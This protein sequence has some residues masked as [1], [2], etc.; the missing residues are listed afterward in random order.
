[1]YAPSEI[2]T[3]SE[4][5]LKDYPRTSS[6]KVRKVDLKRLLEDRHSAMDE[7]PTKHTGT[8]DALAIVKTAWARTLGIDASSIPLNRSIEDFADS[9]TAIRLKGHISRATGVE[10]DTADLM[11]AETIEGQAKLLASKIQSTN[12]PTLDI[13]SPSRPGPPQLDDILPAMGDADLFRQIRQQ[14]LQ[15]IKPL[16]FTWHD[17]VEDVLASWDL[18]HVIFGSVEGSG[19]V[20][21]RATVAMK[22]ASVQQLSD[23]LHATLRNHAM[24][25][26][27]E[28]RGIGNGPPL[29]VIMRPNDQWFEYAIQRVPSVG[30]IDELTAQLQDG[31]YFDSNDYPHPSFQIRIA[32]VESTNAAALIWSAEHSAL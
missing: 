14:A 18:G 31:M 21:Y 32:H 1:M 24:Q 17:D 3:L 19:M 29:R 2:I 26:S 6:G 20:N 11:N 7:Q 9:L 13:V 10:L 16:G 12:R 28:I 25:R 15:A 23:A 30:S 5:G 22:T 27:F 4:L 8:L